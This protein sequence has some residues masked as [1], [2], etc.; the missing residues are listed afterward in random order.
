[1]WRYTSH[2]EPDG[3]ENAT[4]NTFAELTW[5]DLKNIKYPV[6]FLFYNHLEKVELW[7]EVIEMY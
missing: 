7:N 4:H 1:M 3:I 2:N 5:I 6:D